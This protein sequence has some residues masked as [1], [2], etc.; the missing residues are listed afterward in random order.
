MFCKINIFNAL[1]CLFIGLSPL[2]AFC[3]S[4]QES[5]TENYVKTNR[6]IIVGAERMNEWLPLIEGKRVGLIINQT[7]V[8]GTT[9]LIDT[10][11]Q[12]GV[13]I[14]AAFAPEHGVR[15]EADA[16]AQISNEKDLK[17]G[18][19]IFSIYGNNKKP[20]TAQLQNID[21][22]I[23][24]IQDVGTRFYT[25][26]STLEYVMEAAAEQ[27]KKVIVLDRP[28]PNG[29]YVDGP[30]LK[31]SHRSFVGMQAIPVVHGMT[32]G[33]YALMLN[34]EKWLNNE[35]QCDL[36]V[37][38]AE[39]YDHTVF[40]DLP[41]A[42]SPNLP[43]MR[44]IYLYPSLCFFEGTPFSVG[45]GTNQQF[46]LWGHPLSDTKDT[47]FVPE[48]MAGA[49]NPPLLGKQSYG[50]SYTQLSIEELRNFKFSLQPILEA[51]HSYKGQ[52]FFTNF[53]SK[54]AGTDELSTQIKAGWKEDEIRQSWSDDLEQ[55]KKIRKKYLLYPDFE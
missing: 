1:F 33:E 30:V 5:L 54:L 24:D 9:L 35:V 34:G 13:N 8:V 15:G 46:Q 28:N 16:G 53:F 47:V 32:V 43:N 20:S 49:K 29:H 42:P 4:E 19:P 10:L 3:M 39:N 38:K 36:T 37:I 25:Y 40:Y 21:V 41:V 7:S 27:N 26:I 14:S 12:L 50:K 44:S 55:F 51:Y 45:R 52:S 2:T 22:L 18:I 17:T 11:N 48:S 23:F 31:K 6:K